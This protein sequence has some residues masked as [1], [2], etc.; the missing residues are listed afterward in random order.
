[1]S[2]SYGCVGQTS[3]PIIKEACKKVAVACAEHGKSAGM[4]IVV[5]TEENITEAKALGYS[6]IALGTDIYFI[7]DGAKKVIEQFNSIG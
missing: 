2:G 7:R 5:P 3:H 4:H 1:M 6:F